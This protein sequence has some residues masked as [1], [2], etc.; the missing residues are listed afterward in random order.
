M[1]PSKCRDCGAEIYWVKTT[2][3]KSMPANAQPVTSVKRGTFLLKL[4]DGKLEI[5]RMMN[6]TELHTD[7]WPELCDRN[8]YESHFVTCPNAKRRRKK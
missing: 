6:G 3:G 1:Q 8:F 4:R 7:E 2:N 5:E